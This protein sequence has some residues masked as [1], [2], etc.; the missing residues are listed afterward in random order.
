[1]SDY[2]SEYKVKFQQLRKDIDVVL[3]NIDIVFGLKEKI[4][5]PR[6][7]MEPYFAISPGDIKEKLNKGKEIKD[8]ALEL[9]NYFKPL[10]VKYNSKD[11]KKLSPTI[12]VRDID[13]VFPEVKGRNSQFAKD[14]K[15]LEEY[16]SKCDKLEGKIDQ[17]MAFDIPSSDLATVNLMNTVTKEIPEGVLGSLPKEVKNKVD[18]IGL[19]LKAKTDFNALMNQFYNLEAGI[20]T[21]PRYK[22]LPLPGLRT[23]KKDYK[24]LLDDFRNFDTRYRKFIDMTK[25][26]ETYQKI[27][28]HISHLNKYMSLRN[29]GAFM[30]HL[31]Y[32]LI[33]LSTW[34]LL[35]APVGYCYF[36]AIRSSID[37]FTSIS[38]SNVGSI[39]GG[40]GAGIGNGFFKFTTLLSGT[41]YYW[42]S[43]YAD[44]LI[45]PL[46]IQIIYTSVLAVSITLRILFSIFD[47]YD[48]KL[49]TLPLA[50]LNWIAITGLFLMPFILSIAPSMIIGFGT[51][52]WQGAFTIGISEGITTFIGYVTGFGFVDSYPSMVLVNSNTTLV[53]VL[54]YAY[55]LLA[56]LLNF[57][58]KRR[59]KRKLVRVG[60]R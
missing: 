26:E 60:S 4:Y 6:L 18:D 34:L 42:Q 10:T 28:E 5:E 8:K 27:S 9:V 55:I 53:N 23:F 15:E 57:V 29:I 33:P 20:G 43:L 59:I 54:F 32:A 38:G 45:S 21:P 35:L 52:G 56:V 41:G 36:T 30:L 7:L 16:L 39:L 13:Y 12:S 25:Y 46:A 44:M 47:K 19:A 50:I 1:M 48:T 37:L 31:L 24:K 14:Y 2:I 51:G 3:N 40:V 22:F 11:I 17:I 49:I 58:F